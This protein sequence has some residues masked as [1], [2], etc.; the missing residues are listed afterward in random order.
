MDNLILKTIIFI[1][2]DKATHEPVV[3][4]HFQG[5]K[6]D[7][8]ATEFSRYLTEQFVSDDLSPNRTLH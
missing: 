1:M 5:F 6:D 3:I 2:K 8:E 7:Q 4:T